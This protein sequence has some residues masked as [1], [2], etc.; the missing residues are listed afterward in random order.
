MNDTNKNP[1]TEAELEDLVACYIHME[2]YTDFR[3]IYIVMKQ[4]YPGE[5]DHK[6][7]VQVIRRVLR[8]ERES[9]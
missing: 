5:F 4:E 1:M 8:E 6:L 9:R 2:G 3:S 7:A